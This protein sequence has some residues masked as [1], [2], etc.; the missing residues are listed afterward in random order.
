MGFIAIPVVTENSDCFFYH[1]MDFPDG[2]SIVGDWDLRGRFDDYTGHVDLK[3]KTVLDVGTASGFLAFEAEKRG[4]Q[5]ISLDMPIDGD[6][7]IVPYAKEPV[8]D[9]EAQLQA[10]LG[11]KNFNKRTTSIARMRKGYFYAHRKMNSNVRFFESV[12]YG[13]SEELGFMDVSIV[14]SIL[15]HLRDPFLALQKVASITK[16]RIVIAD[17]CQQAFVKQANQRPLLEFLPN[18]NLDNPHAWWRLSPIAL[19]SMLGVVGFEVES[20][21]TNTFLFKGRELRVC[22]QVAR[23]VRV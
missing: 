12:V 3:N 10:R 6:W 21:Q 23:R 5:V 18:A 14:G 11:D 1:S 19:N 2:T 8:A 4:A 9:I 22:T 7:D 17:L 20:E 13:I 16:E 15:L